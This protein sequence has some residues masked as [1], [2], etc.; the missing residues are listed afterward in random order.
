MRDPLSGAKKASKF[1]SDLMA[2][3]A[4][5]MQKA[6]QQSMSGDSFDVNSLSESAQEEYQR[7][8]DGFS[9][10]GIT[11][12][13]VQK[14]CA[15]GAYE[16]DQENPDGFKVDGLDQALSDITSEGG[17]EK[18][19]STAGMAADLGTPSAEVEL[20]DVGGYPKK[21]RLGSDR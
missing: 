11:G 4:G 16:F 7:C 12:D 6:D 5:D 20:T 10:A 17:V 1:V 8:M 15:L 14:I 9:E 18:T 13:S 21:K 19:V 3:R 2:A